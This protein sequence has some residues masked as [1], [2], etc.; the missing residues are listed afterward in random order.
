M[1]RTTLNA[2]ETL[3]TTISHEISNLLCLDVNVVT[4]V[5]DHVIVEIH[6]VHNNHWRTLIP[7]V[8]VVLLYPEVLEQ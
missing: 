8:R 7:L 5:P 3:F 2:E 1:F 6:H 4:F